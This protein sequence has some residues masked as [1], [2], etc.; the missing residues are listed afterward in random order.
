MISDISAQRAVIGPDLHFDVP[1]WLY[2]ART[3]AAGVEVGCR[4]VALV[5]D[6]KGSPRVT[7]L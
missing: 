1:E 3:G 6:C 2:V 4:L 7:L 5:R